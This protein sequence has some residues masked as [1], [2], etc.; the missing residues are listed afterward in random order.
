MTGAQPQRS[1]Y[2]NKNFHTNTLTV[3]TLWEWTGGQ[4]QLRFKLWALTSNFSLY[5]CGSSVPF[6]VAKDLFFVLPRVW[7]LVE[8]LEV[9]VVL[10]AKDNVSPFFR[11]WFLALAHHYFVINNSVSDSNCVHLWG[12]KGQMRPHETVSMQSAAAGKRAITVHV[13][14][15]GRLFW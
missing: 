1:W 12:K 6:F 8:S 14:Q 7:L 9:C 5:A 15:R 13:H 3:D 4:M 2:V 10:G 11:T